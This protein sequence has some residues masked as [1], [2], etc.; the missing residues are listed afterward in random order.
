MEAAKTVFES[1]LPLALGPLEQ[2]NHLF[3]PGRVTPTRFGGVR[4]D[5]LLSHAFLKRYAWTLDFA[6]R[7]YLFSQ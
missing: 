1:R 3:L 4:I 6:N 7:E 2:T 5:A